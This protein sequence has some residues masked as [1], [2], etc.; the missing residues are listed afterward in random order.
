MDLQDQLVEP[1]NLTGLPEILRRM[2]RHATAILCDLPQ[3]LSAH[4]LRFPLRHF[5]CQ[6]RVAVREHDHRVADDQA[7]VIEQLFLPCV[8]RMQ[9]QRLKGLLNLAPDPGIA[10]FQDPL[11]VDDHMAEAAGLVVPDRVD[12]CI[13]AA[14]GRLLRQERQQMIL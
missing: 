4:R 13:E 9:R 3:L 12:H 1:D 5:I 14:A 11:M 7:G 2:L 6:R 8:R 10:L